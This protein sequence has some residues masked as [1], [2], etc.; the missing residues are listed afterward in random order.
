MTRIKIQ[1]KGKSTTYLSFDK[2]FFGGGGEVCFNALSMKCPLRGPNSFEDKGYVGDL[3]QKTLD[4]M[5]T[6]YDDD[7]IENYINS[8]GI[9][10][11]MIRKHPGGFNVKIYN[12]VLGVGSRKSL[13]YY[14]KFKNK[15]P[16]IFVRAIQE[17]RAACFL[18]MRLELAKHIG[19]RNPFTVSDDELCE[20]AAESTLAKNGVEPETVSFNKVY[21]HI[22]EI[23]P[24][25]SFPQL[26]SYELK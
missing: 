10:T 12:S 14:T 20:L 1:S 13:I 6:V 2:D 9:D 25:D 24:S 21:C 17:A 11:E 4:L 19:K 16:D 15:T 7:V 5:R 18:G 22:L 23:P 3:W 26:T 8:E